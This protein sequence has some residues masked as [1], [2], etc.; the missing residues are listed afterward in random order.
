[1][2]GFDVLR[3]VRQRDRDRGQ[4]TV[5]LALS[6][7]ASEHQ[8]ADSLRAGFDDHISKPYDITHLTRTICDALARTST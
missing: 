4:H 8:Q 5:A 6:A 2:N 7:H 1:V 3:V